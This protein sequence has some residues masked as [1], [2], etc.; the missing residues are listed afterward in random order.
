MHVVVVGGGPAGATAAERLALSGVQTTLVEK[1]ATRPKTCGGALTPPVLEEFDLPSALVERTIRT[2]RL[3]PP[4]NRFVDICLP[5]PVSLVRREKLD[6]FLRHRA[7]KAGA[8]ILEEACLSIRRRGRQHPIE[9]LVG[10]DTEPQTLPADVVI[11]ADGA[12]SVVAQ[13][14]GL[15]RPC[16]L[17]AYQERIEM[18]PRALRLADRIEIHFRADVSPDFYGWVFPKADHLCVGTA[19]WTGRRRLAA[20]LRRLKDITGL[21]GAKVLRR[22][23]GFLPLRSRPRLVAGRVLLV[24]DAGGFV[25]PISGEGIYY[26]MKSGQCAASAVLHALAENDVPNGLLAYQRTWPGI[27]WRMTRGLGL[28]QRFYYSQDSR[29]ECFVSVCSHPAVKQ[30]AFFSYLDKRV[31][32]FLTWGDL[33]VALINLLALL[34]SA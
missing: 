12:N 3:V 18:T 2:V 14:L 34:K 19:S 21:E 33:R 24:G 28:A 30:A 26:A 8:R 27:F 22:E 10:K 5:R 15:A 11:G 20:S 7:Q 6:V 13:S 4:S 23:A 25:S 31:P 16:G 32:S 9:V 29:R 1:D 17:L